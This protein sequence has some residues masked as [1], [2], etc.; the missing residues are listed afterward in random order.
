ME[1]FAAR[2]F[3]ATSTREIAKKLGCTKATL[4]YYFDTKESLLLAMLDPVAEALE[5]RVR[6]VSAPEPDA[7]APTPCWLH[8]L[9]SDSRKCTPGLDA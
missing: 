4:Y 5:S 6:G 9:S 3:A 8:R 2:G 7:A 1:L